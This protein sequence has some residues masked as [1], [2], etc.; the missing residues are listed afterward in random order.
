MVVPAPTVTQ[1]ALAVDLDQTAEL[2][3]AQVHAVGRRNGR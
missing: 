1:V 3:Q 2:V